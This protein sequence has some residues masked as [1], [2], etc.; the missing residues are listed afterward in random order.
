[1][2]T[3]ATIITGCLNGMAL[4]LTPI[5][6][7][8]AMRKLNTDFMVDRWFI[9]VGITAIILLS[10]VFFIVT[11]KRMRQERRLSGQLFDEYADKRGLSSRERQ[12]LF[13]VAC[14]ARL[15]RNESIYTLVTAY[16]RGSA[17]VIEQGL[18]D[19]QT[20]E[21]RNQ[22][23][24]ELSFLREKLGFKKRISLTTSSFAKLKKLSSRQ[25]PVG[26]KI[27]M[28]RRM[29]Q[30]SE[31]IEAIIVKNSDT[32]LAIRLSGSIKISFGEPWCVRYY[33]GSSVWEFDTSVISYDGDM[34]FLNHND[35]V[36]FINRRRFLR[37]P[38]KMSGFV[39]HFT[40]ERSVSEISSNGNV[41]P[42]MTRD[43]VNGSPVSWGPPK[44]VPA[45]VTE[46]AGPGLRIETSLKVK[47]GERILVVFNLT[48][49]CDSNVLDYDKKLNVPQIVQ[50]IGE[51]RHI[52][53]VHNGLSIAVELI[54]L[55]DSNVNKLICAANATSLTANKKDQ[56]VSEDDVERAPVY[57]GV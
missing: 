18:T 36:K 25:I 19:H 33:F 7:Y 43:L 23:E 10:V 50:D 29:S 2:I 41:G 14:K 45:M 56:L 31:D 17:V 51:V 1:M 6:R 28:T 49:E 40:F 38:V 12:I 55:S 13:R 32:E 11:F 39:A 34:L 42:M 30:K 53:P 16:D 21:E 37:V 27:H 54:G 5:E 48:Q 52:K 35:D 3:M 24:V 44:Y 8:A 47:V 9:T 4:A 22:L 46:L 57:I 26:K 20:N 15:K